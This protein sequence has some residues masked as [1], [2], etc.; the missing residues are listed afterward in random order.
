M[1]INKQ[2]NKIKMAKNIKIYFLALLVV[3]ASLKSEAISIEDGKFYPL[4]FISS[5]KN[6]LFIFDFLKIS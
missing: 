6:N 4:I 3:L 1:K 2:K 5:F